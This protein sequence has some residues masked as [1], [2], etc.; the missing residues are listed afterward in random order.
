MITRIKKSNGLFV[1]LCGLGCLF[2]VQACP[3]SVQAGHLQWTKS[4]PLPEPRAG[5]AAGVLDGKL[6]IA[7]GTYWEGKKGHWTKKIFSASTHAFDPTSQKWERLPDAPIP[8]GYAAFTV[9]KNRLYVLGGYTGTEASRKIF[10]LERQGHKYVWKVFGKLPETRLFGWATDIG[11]SIYLLGG[12]RQFEPTDKTGTCC[13][14]KTATTRLTVFDTAHP[15][16]GWRDLA[17]YPG[18]KRWLF[19][20]ETDGETIWMLGG[21]H[22][23]NAEDV[24]TKFSGV[25]SYS[26]SKDRWKKLPP[27]PPETLNARPL[28]SMLAQNKIL[29]MSFAKTVWQFDLSTMEYTKLAPLPE[30]AFV[31][32]FVWLNN[33]IIGAG[34]ENKIEG[35]RRRSEWTFIGKFVSD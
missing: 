26:I 24:P 35:P 14:S 19:S 33:Q 5:Y 7:G 10:T 12:V 16:R 6:V 2:L 29:L 18:N 8:F 13:T 31:D 30:E 25:L 9:V 32:K 28:V 1:S 4:T 11:S 27:L 22:T 20:A 17:P 15:Q 34:G 3:C 23:E 21:T